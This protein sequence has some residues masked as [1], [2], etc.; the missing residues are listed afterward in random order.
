[1][2]HP[3]LPATVRVLPGTDVESLW[4]RFR[5]F[6]ALHH[7]MDIMNPLTSADLDEVLALLEV[8]DGDRV[9]DIASGHGEL[10]LRSATRH[11]IVGTGIDLS[12]WVVARAARR[13]AETPLRGSIEWW[14][15]PAEDFAPEPSRDAATC[16][17]ASWIWGGFAGTVR[18]LVQRCRPGGRIAIG[19]L[20]LLPGASPGDVPE[21]HRP[22]PSREDQQRVLI[23]AGVTP[24]AEVDTG[25][26]GWEVYDRRTAASAETYREQHPGEQADGFLTEQR[27]WVDEHAAASAA[28]AWTVWVGRVDG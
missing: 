3:E 13:A 12:P 17:G 7:G 1:M 20:R 25:P 14:L 10:L 16:L 2:D 11:A 5:V 19:D 18:A 21:D 6:E 28:L 9:L 23:A 22:A 8:S 15:G 4:E 24:I 27:R 26:E